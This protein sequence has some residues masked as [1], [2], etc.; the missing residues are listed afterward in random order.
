MLQS[1]SKEIQLCYRKAEEWAREAEI[2]Q[3]EALRTDYL[4]SEQSWLKLARSYELGQRL[5]LFVSESQKPESNG[6]RGG[7]Q[8]IAACPAAVTA[9]IKPPDGGKTGNDPK[10]RTNELIAVVDDDEWARSGLRTLIESLGYRV[11]AFASAEEYL[12]S[13]MRECTACLILDVYMPGMSGPDLQAHLVAGGRCPPTIFAT[14]R[15]EE[16]VRKR[17]IEAGALGYLKKPCDETALLE[18]LGKVARTAASGS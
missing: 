7:G 15:F 13:D 18:C 1:L 5:T 8:A 4:R 11:A 6:N 10:C 12:A 2:I 9:R 3:D 17:V 14:G 16:H